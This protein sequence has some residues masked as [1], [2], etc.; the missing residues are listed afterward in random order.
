[1]HYQVVTSFVLDAA[2]E[3]AK[4]FV[5]TLGINAASFT[6]AMRHAE[7]LA[8]SISEGKG[9]LDMVEIQCVSPSDWP[10]DVRKHFVASLDIGGVYLQTGRV[11][12]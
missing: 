3:G 4:G 8:G 2:F 9:T 11:Y 6:D 10:V 1:M 5:V 12:F 7:A